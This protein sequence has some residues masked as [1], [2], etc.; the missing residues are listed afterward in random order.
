MKSLSTAFAALALSMAASASAGPL[1][2]SNHSL[3][4]S[5]GFGTA[6]SDTYLFTLDSTGW[7]RG[8]LFTNAALGGDPAVDVQSVLLRRA[9]G[10]VGWTESVAIDWDV[11]ETGVEHWALSPRLLAAGE[12][13]LVVSGLSYADKAGNG[14]DADM[15]LPEP[16]SMALAV[17]ALMGAGL[18]RLRRRAV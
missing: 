6:F 2:F 17:L 15:H 12:W 3:Q 14:Y 10:D 9:G 16:Q 8:T 1:S 18:A 7:L 4:D 11:A 13:Q 5:T